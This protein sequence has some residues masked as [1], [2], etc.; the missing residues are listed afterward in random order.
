V[1]L[2]VGGEGSTE[3]ARSY[4]TETLDR[5]PAFGAPMDVLDFAQQQQLLVVPLALRRL[6]SGYVLL[7]HPAHAP[8]P[9]SSSEPPST[10]APGQTIDGMLKLL[11][12]QAA[13]ALAFL[14]GRDLT[15]GGG[16]IKDPTS[17]A[18]SFAYYVDVAGREIDKARRHG[19]RF[20]IATVALDP[21]A[22]ASSSGLPPEVPMRPAEVADHLLK[23]ARDL[24]VLARV[25]ENEFHLLL[26]ETDGLGA[27]ACRR[28][29]LT[30]LG[31]GERRIVPKG[32]LVGIATFPHDG[33]NLS[34]LLRM[35]RRRAEVTKG[36]IVHRIGV[37]NAGL[38]DILDAL[39][40]D[41]T[42]A[43][44]PS[45][46]S[47]ARPIELPIAEAT[48][49]ATAVVA[50]ACRGGAAFIVVAHHVALSLG[51]AV[52]ASIGT[53]NPNVTVHALDVRSTPGGETIEA[54]SV[55]A[56]HGAY[57][58][59]G[60]SKNGVVRGVHAADPLLADLLAERLGRAA[61]LRIFA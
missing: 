42:S 55:I 18:Y 7:L 51:S 22:P 54:L 50:D 56:E 23:A 53:G 20:A 31:G 27:H 16:A 36:S 45:D 29:V 44:A 3:L 43:P 33:Q 17:S 10:T 24:D 26:P 15:D 32:L 34:Q 8:A 12:V 14:G 19:R 60:R 30:R 1:Y 25:D 49:L 52:R 48:A 58:F 11:A 57:A 47:A 13:S 61:G 38:G 40:W 21:D 9:P 5:A 2:V 37:E 59:I 39:E 28:R 6:V 4:A 41:A 35:A 46:I